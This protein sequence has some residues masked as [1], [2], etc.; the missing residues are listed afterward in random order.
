MRSFATLFSVQNFVL[1]LATLSTLVTVSAAPLPLD[2]DTVILERRTKTVKV[3]DK[4]GT[5]GEKLSHD[6]HVKSTVHELSHWDGKDKPN[7]VVKTYNGDGKVNHKEV[8]GLQAAGQYIHHDDKSVVMHQV[9]GTPLSHMVRAVPHDQRKA[10]VDSWKPKVAE[11]VAHIAKT[12]GVMHNDLNMNNV[13]VH[14]EGHVQLVDWEH[15]HP[16]GH[17]EFTDDKAKIHKNLDLVW[18]STATPPEG[19]SK[20]KSPPKR[21]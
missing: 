5:L 14:P 13:I 16:K 3:G 4:S 21:R 20:S 7:A 9:H 10:M 2:S 17:A 8:T 15:F 1:S 6:S 19:K 12:K 18:D 11:H